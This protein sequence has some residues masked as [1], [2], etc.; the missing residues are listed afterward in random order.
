MASAPELHTKS[1]FSPTLPERLRPKP[2]HKNLQ[3]ARLKHRP[4]ASLPV[5]PTTP[6]TPL[7]S[8]F[9]R[10]FFALPVEIRLQIY[11]H[12]LVRPNK[13]NLKHKFGCH[14]GIIGIH[15][16]GIFERLYLSRTF[17]CAECDTRLWYSRDQDPCQELNIGPDSGAR[18]Y[19]ARPKKNPYLCDR[20][21]PE[22][23]Y[24]LGLEKWPSLEGLECLCVRREELA[25]LAVNRRIY[26]EAWPVFW[27]ENTFAFENARLLADFLENVPDEKRERIRS[28]SL[29]A[30]R[31]NRHILF[32]DEE[33]LAVCWPLLRKCTGLRHLEIDSDLLGDLDCVLELSAV[34]VGEV[35]FMVKA[36]ERGFDS[37]DQGYRERMMTPWLAYRRI[38][39]D[40]LTV[41]LSRSM[42]G[43]EDVDEEC[44]LRAFEKRERR[45]HQEAA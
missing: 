39:E 33:E 44:V 34:K 5:D 14:V 31:G 2:K 32:E 16:P 27:A 13:F 18:S 40:E 45:I 28:I 38:C 7:D 24:R 9:L 12:I 4:P 10:L 23:Q 17:C 43:E 1:P 41:L 26:E 42:M 35:V 37:Y 21:Y 25:V 20:C 6:E 30:P 29:L 15:R 11:R 8:P 19:W 36:K 3:K 22:M